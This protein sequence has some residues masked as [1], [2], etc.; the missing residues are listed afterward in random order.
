MKAGKWIKALRCAGFLC[1]LGLLLVFSGKIL[2]EK[3][4]EFLSTDAERAV[5]EGCDV[6]FLG[7]ST[8]MN[9]VYP[10]ELWHEFGISAY[11]CGTGSQSLLTS[12]YL[13]KE[14]L[15]KEEPKLIVLDCGKARSKRSI[16]K[17]GYL[18]YITDILPLLSPERLQ[19][20]RA[21]ADDRKY[22]L[23][24]TSGLLLPVL[25]Y[26]GRWADVSSKDLAADIKK[27]TYG[28]KVDVRTHTDVVPF[29]DY[30]ASPD[31]A[32]PAMAETCLR[33][34][35]ELASDRGIGLL[36]VTMPNMMQA[37]DVDQKEYELRVDSAAAL[38]KV[39]DEYGTGHL[40]LIKEGEAIGLIP[41]EDTADGQHLT[42]RG[43]SKFT[44]FIG[45]YI[46]EHYEV[47]DH[48]A[49]SAYAHLN[50]KYEAF[51]AYINGRTAKTA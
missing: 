30:E 31:A 15:K 27:V 10:L 39:A 28:A 26:H 43:A 42:N 20:I 38:Q 19:M 16:V 34:I 2:R 37:Y 44:R 8:V 29:Q 18:H 51:E 47:P 4:G 17:I 14:L 35:I 5:A 22:T 41:D 46:R 6:L 45:G 13:I 48:T 33:K 9:A 40:N 23:D 12:Y 25:A 49:E 3:S 11:N 21:C 36:L 1:I 7:P 32:L 50:G 24:E